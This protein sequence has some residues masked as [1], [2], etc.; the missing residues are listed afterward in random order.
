MVDGKLG[1]MQININI[2][3]QKKVTFDAFEPLACLWREPTYILCSGETFQ[4]Y[5]LQK[6]ICR[7]LLFLRFAA[8][9][10]GESACE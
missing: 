2:D 10:A 9:K 5:Y 7:C 3:K 4:E 1:N 6:K 8:Q